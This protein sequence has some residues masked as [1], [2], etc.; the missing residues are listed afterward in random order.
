MTQWIDFYKQYRDILESD[1]IHLRRPD[2]RDVDG[3]LHVNPQSHPRA[4]AM[5]YNP[6]DHSVSKSVSLPLYFAGIHDSVS[7]REREG[8]AKDYPVDR[9]YN[10]SVPV[11]LPANGH[12]WLVVE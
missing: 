10:V 8:V 7:I 2:G 12:T 11:E 1:I 5:L 6:L 9:A 3:I 4:L